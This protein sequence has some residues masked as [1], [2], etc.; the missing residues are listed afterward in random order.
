MCEH[1]AK[2]FFRLQKNIASFSDKQAR[3]SDFDDDLNEFTV[4]IIP[5]GGLYNRGKFVF[6]I[7]PGA[8]YP[9]EAPRVESETMIYHPNIDMSEDFERGEICLNL[10]SE[11][12][13]QND[14]EDCVQ[15]LLFLLYNPN[16]EDPLNPWF[17]PD[18]DNEEFVENVL[19]SLQ[20]GN[21][22]GKEF[23][24]N[25]IEDSENNSLHKQI[26][27]TESTCALEKNTDSRTEKCPG[28]RV[29]TDIL[30]R[31]VDTEILSRTVDTEILPRTVDRMEQYE[32]VNG[33]DKG[34]VQDIPQV[35]VVAPDGQCTPVI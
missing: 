8:N 26:T 4:E 32:R 13:Q 30:S 25:I 27:P 20:G 1:L 12:T 10:F 24:R 34:L 28:R 21:V 22:E 2:D 29:D 23:E 19:K 16:L 17:S 9:S 33:T 7:V 3:V 14:L 6:R 11:W 31:T 35:F 5:N 15:G 18:D